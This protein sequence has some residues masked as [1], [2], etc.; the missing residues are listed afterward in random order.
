MT[1]TPKPRTPIR[2]LLAAARALLDRGGFSLAI[3]AAVVLLQ[4]LALPLSVIWLGEEGAKVA[5]LA[6][7]AAAALSFVRARAADRLARSVRLNLLELYLSPFEV[8]D[9]VS[10]P[11]HETITARL[12]IALPTLVGWAVEGVAVV[13]GAAFAVPLVAALI[14][15][16]LGVSALIPLGVAGAAG[17]IV[18][19]ATSPRVESAWGRAWDRSRVFLEAI[20][21]GYQGAIDLRAHGRARA[22]A[23]TL[24]A[25]V[26]AWSAAEGRARTL[27]AFSS[28]GALVAT[29]FAALAAS[30]IFTPDLGKAASK[31]GVYRAFMLVLAA[32]PTLQTFVGATAS[33]L[34]ARDELESVER[35][36]GIAARVVAE[37][38]GAIDEPIDVKARVELAGI[39]LTYRSEGE[40]ATKDPADGARRTAALRG[41]ALTIEE[42]ESVAI[43]G[44]NGAGKTTLLYI[45][46]G[47]LRPDAGSI[48]VGG[49][50]ARLDNPRWRERVAFLSQ[51]PFERREATIAENM[52]AFDPGVPDDRLVKALMDVGLFDGLRRRSSSDAGALALPYAELSRGQARR[53]MLARALLRDADLLVLDE[54][55]A[56]LDA[57]SIASIAAILTRLTHDRRVIAV[58][59]DQAIA[60]FAS[61]VITLEP[62]PGPT[63]SIDES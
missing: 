23:D 32:V 43:T 57:E 39:D 34:Y 5:V 53:V 3:I 52:R 18:T 1:R 56:H 62:P 24:R 26:D 14:A 51:R 54:P 20:G 4:R 36:R 59:H 45:L 28:W 38:R 58:V 9:V 29:L 16:E 11:H 25:D 12:A 13:V 44:P 47:V 7:F 41:A 60:A 8:G 10:L 15:S 49:R 42:G 22:F 37:G 30:A 55:E 6:L 35:Q 17:A 19:M 46:L 2:L 61:R 63:R 33:L 50:E 48:R 31:E 21:A 40:A 27:S